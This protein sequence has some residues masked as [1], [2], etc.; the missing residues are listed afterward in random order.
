MRPARPSVAAPEGGGL[1]GGERLAGLAE[2]G[3]DLTSS[4]LSVRPELDERGQ[5]RRAAEAG[6]VSGAGL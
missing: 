1:G 5:Q 6:W 4:D 3:S 2:V